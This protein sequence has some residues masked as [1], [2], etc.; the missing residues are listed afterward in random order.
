MTQSAKFYTRTMAK[1]YADQGYLRKAAEIYH[2][3]IKQNPERDDLR[4]ALSGVEEQIARQQTPTSKE[5]R[6]MFREWVDLMT[7]YNSL[8]RQKQTQSRREDERNDEKV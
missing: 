1:L 7:H 4:Q 2:H 6:L 5:L 8:Q 3:L